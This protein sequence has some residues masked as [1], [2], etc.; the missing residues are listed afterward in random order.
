M[1]ASVSGGG[2]IT[3]Y[4]TPLLSNG[5]A[6]GCPGRYAGYV[7]YSKPP[8][9]GWGWSPIA[10]M[11]HTVTD[12]NRTDTKVQYSGAYGD[13]GCNQTTV[14]VNPAYS[15]VYQFT[16]Y[17]TNNVPTNAYPMVLLSGFNP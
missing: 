15:P 17:F 14:L 9:Q 1:T 4:G 6:G 5:S 11:T 3:V 7:T 2:P 8:S 16:I 10:G 12:T 13:N